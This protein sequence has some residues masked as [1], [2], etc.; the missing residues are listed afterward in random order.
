MNKMFNEKMLGINSTNVNDSL[1]SY[2]G[3]DFLL[4]KPEAAYN[5]KI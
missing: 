3:R 5:D 4:E 2:F 1:N